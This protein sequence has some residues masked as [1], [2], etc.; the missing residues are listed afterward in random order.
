MFEAFNLELMFR[1]DISESSKDDVSEEEK[2]KSESEEEQHEPQQPLQQQQQ[3]QFEHH[4][5]GRLQSLPVSTLFPTIS[6]LLLSKSTKLNFGLSVYS[7]A[8]S[9]HYPSIHTLDRDFIVS[10]NFMCLGSLQERVP[11]EIFEDDSIDY[12]GDLE[13]AANIDEIEFSPRK[14]AY[15]RKVMQE[16]HQGQKHQS[17]ILTRQASDLSD[18]YRISS[19][20][21]AESYFL[22]KTEKLHDQAVCGD[23]DID[24][25]VQD[26]PTG[27]GN[28]TGLEV[29]PLS[30]EDEMEILCLAE[31]PVLEVKDVSDLSSD[32]SSDIRV[33]IQHH[34][35][36]HHQGR[37]AQMS[38]FETLYEQG[39]AVQDPMSGAQGHPYQ[40]HSQS[41]QGTYPI[42]ETMSSFE[43]LYQKQSQEPEV[44]GIFLTEER[45]IPIQIEGQ[46]ST[47]ETSVRHSLPANY[48]DQAAASSLSF[49]NDGIRKYATTTTSGGSPPRAGYFR[50]E[51]RVLRELTLIDAHNFL[52]IK[53]GVLLFIL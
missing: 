32:L 7:V 33:P 3:Q 25:V 12:L 6:D 38:S 48:F 35:P 28:D 50:F 42:P 44:A 14:E 47:E 22:R 20:P 9:R 29:V 5:R 45:T 15:F 34:H 18:S 39:A 27:N 13:G 4:E 46:H 11:S 2:G 41:F 37:P 53:D 40:Q 24:V 43:Q 30:Q 10:F 51:A 49:S 31:D 23:L 17:K 21:E 1:L 36:I 52:N 16:S 26:D 19:T 8:I